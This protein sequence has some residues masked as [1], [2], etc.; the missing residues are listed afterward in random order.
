[1]GSPRRLNVREQ[2][3]WM[4][5]HLPIFRTEVEGR[6]LV[7][8]GV[9]RPTALS[10]EYN[11]VIHYE[12]GYRPRVFI[13]GGQLQRRAENEPIPHTYADDEPCLYYPKNVEWRSDMK[14]A[15]SVV[16]WLSLWLMY[17]E[18]WRATGEWQGGGIEHKAE[19]KPTA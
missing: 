11:V 16:S 18:I 12:F 8:R 10:R 7:C 2:A 1:M 14:I 6:E 19:E 5:H 13:P 9:L 3:A 15:T 17:Y 4:R